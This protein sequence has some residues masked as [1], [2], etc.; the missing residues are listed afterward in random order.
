LSLPRGAGGCI[1]LRDETSGD[2]RKTTIESRPNGV[3]SHRH[4]HGQITYNNGRAQF[5]SVHIQQR[6]GQRRA[7]VTGCLQ[8]GGPE[9]HIPRISAQIT[10]TTI[11]QPGMRCWGLVL[12]PGRP[13]TISQQR[14][15]D[16]KDQCPDH[17]HHN[18]S[19]RDAVLGV[20]L[21]SRASRDLDLSSGC[22]Y[23]A[24][25]LEGTCISQAL[26]AHVPPPRVQE[27]AMFDRGTRGWFLRT[28]FPLNLTA[29]PGV[30][31]CAQPWATP[32]RGKKKFPARCAR[33]CVPSPF[34]QLTTLTNE[35]ACE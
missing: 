8:E 12:Y 26:K 29:E 10:H 7:P 32:Y 30:G 13:G 18:T 2:N 25:G 28:L 3:P 11:H 9:L 35:C 27:P 5:R 15:P 33:T 23:Q 6:E 31:S 34:P 22:P 20:G 24:S 14:M 19:T 1:V 21:I 16:T 4:M 17:T